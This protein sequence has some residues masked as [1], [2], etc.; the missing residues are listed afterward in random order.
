[1]EAITRHGFIGDRSFMGLDARHHRGVV[2]LW[3]SDN[4][5]DDIGRHLL[6]ARYAV[7]RAH[8]A[9]HTGRVR[10]RQR[11]RAYSHRSQGLDFTLPKVH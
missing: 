8:Y 7:A 4:N 9:K 10:Q 1:L 2:V 6:D 5:L 3:N 11:R